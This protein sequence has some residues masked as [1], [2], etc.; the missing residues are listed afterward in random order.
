MKNKLNKSFLLIL[1]AILFMACNKQPSVQEYYV[2]KQNNEN[3]I[4]IDLPASIIKLSEEASEE[5]KE[6]MATIK[7]LNILAFQINDD[8]QAAYET[9]Y[10]SIKEIIKGDQYNELMRMKHDN[11][12]IV[13]N[14][15]GEDDSVDEFLLFA[16]DRKQGFALA[17]ILG[18][19][20][21]PSKIMKLANDMKGFDQDGEGYSELTN[22]FKGID[23]N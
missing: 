7:K 12:N 22:L 19:N 14:Y 23:V 15:Q 3:F 20:M 8:N 21:Q 9:E 10:A 13:I 1:T 6:T 18:D 11:F 5:T 4:A 16:A 17:R 2:E